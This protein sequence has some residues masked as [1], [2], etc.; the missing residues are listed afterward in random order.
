MNTDTATPYPADP[1]PPIPSVDKRERPKPA[2]TRNSTVGGQP[3]MHL[4]PALMVETILKR[5]ENILEELKGHRARSASVRMLILGILCYLTYG[6]LVGSFSGGMQWW[7]T[8]VKTAGGIVFSA[9][10]C[11]PSLYIFGCIARSNTSIL[12]CVGLLTGAIALSGMLLIGFLPVGWV[13][14]TSTESVQFMGFLHLLFW[15]VAL[16]FGIRFISNGMEAMDAKNNAPI[17]IWIVIFVLVCLQM[18][19]TLRPLVGPSWRFLAEGKR[20]FLTHWTNL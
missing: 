13:F 2:L 14:S 19:T 17:S 10:L 3:M 16:C 8:P 18:T 5:P 1:P 9:L 15:F 7:A 12:Q 6:L 4:G 20:F 11:L